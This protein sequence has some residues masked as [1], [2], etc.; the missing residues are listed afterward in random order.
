MSAFNRNAI[1]ETTVQESGQLLSGALTDHSF[2]GRRNPF[3]V[4]WLRRWIVVVTVILAMIAAV[5]VIL[6]T[7]PQFSSSSRVN[8]GQAP[9]RLLGTEMG[10]VSTSMN[11][12]NTQCEII[13][14]RRIIQQVI[15]LPQI[16]DL[17]TM[18]GAGSEDPVLFLQS[19]VKANV[20]RRDDLIT[21]SAKAPNPRDSQTIANAVVDAFI[22]DQQSQR[23][24]AAAD[25]LTSLQKAKVQAEDELSKKYKERLDFQRSNANLSLGSDRGNAIIDRLNQLSIS[26]TT[27]QM[28]FLQLNSEYESVKAMLGDPQKLAQLMNSPQFRADTTDLRREMREASQ[29][30]YTMSNSYLPGYGGFGA[31][32][33]RIKRLSDDLAAEDR[34]AAEAYLAQLEARMTAAQ[35]RQASIQQYLDKQREQVLMLNDKA[36]Q[37][38]MIEADIRRLELS[39]NNVYDMM[40][41]L[42]LA[43]DVGL[44][45]ISV[46]ETAMEGVQVEPDKPSIIMIALLSGLVMGIGLAYLREFTDQRL[47]SADEIK[48]VVGLPILG[49]V[50]HIQNARTL[51]QRGLAVH[52][53]PM[54][55]VAEAYRTIR[56]AV[57]FGFPE[58]TAKTILCTS[59]AP[60]DGKSTLASNLAA[61]MAQAGNKILLLDAD[62]R[63]PAQH[64]IFE[65]KTKVGLS[66]V[67]AGESELDDAILETPVAGLHLLPCGPIP[68][69]PSE[70]L[71]SQ[72]FADLLEDLSTRY[73][74]ILLDSP[75]VMPVT[76]SRIL[77]ASC[78]ATIL[79]LRAE[80]S[81]RKGGVY[82]RDTLRSVGSRLL[83][84]V[85]NDVPRRKGVYGYYYSETES[86]SYGYISSIKNNGQKALPANAPKQ[87]QDVG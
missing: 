56:T 8:V 52:L 57:Y 14:S 80:K 12:L 18:K 77:A 37:Y 60:G 87:G 21:V 49:V 50:P 64:K 31:V 48:Q 68:A 46:V 67:L 81:T 6:R 29:Q 61:A 16:R 7:T 36:A 78:D 13:R 40:K 15:N 32:Q 30:L 63:K 70:I 71:N 17:E 75:P 62:F 5:V 34:R 39:C 20:G 45:K 55:D 25:M 3:Q 47:R 76:D 22:A 69:N 41:Q 51:Q 84:V 74:H 27:A 43:D 42:K 4:I 82:A 66:S 44:Q 35:N 28:E 59:P 2:L 79:N 54:S 83:G 86:Y 11:F 26:L 1:V 38:A 24:S 23:R 10:A 85:V 72:T 65:L 53:D 33:A 19:H 73:D 9:V 58:G